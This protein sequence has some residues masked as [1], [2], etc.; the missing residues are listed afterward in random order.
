MESRF[1]KKGRKIE[2]SGTLKGTSKNYFFPL[3]GTFFV[4]LS[5]AKDLKGKARKDPSA[6]PQDDRLEKL[7]F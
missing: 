1:C 6:S 7:N 4:I 5:A 2:F 3:Q